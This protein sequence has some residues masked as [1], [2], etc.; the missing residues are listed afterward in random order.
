MKK[1]ENNYAFVDSQN[2]NMGVKEA[3]WSLDFG[4]FFIYFKEKY[5]VKKTYLFIGYIPEN[6]N[7]YSKLQEFG[8]VLVFKPVLKN[9]NGQAKGNVD[10]DLVLKALVNLN[11]CDKAVIVSS[12]GDFYC[13]VDYLYGRKK[14]QCVLSPNKKKC[15]V[16]LR[17][18]AKEKMVFM[19]NLQE[20]LSYKK[21]NTA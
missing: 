12:D 14:L 18:S 4:K 20:K 21:K 9:K 6:Q 5:S 3:G 1:Q 16:L 13:L 11:N 17:K 19:D 7:L 8:Y 10:A 15:S 2:L